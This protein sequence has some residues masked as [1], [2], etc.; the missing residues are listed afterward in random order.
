MQK[1]NFER[2]YLEIKIPNEIILKGVTIAT[3]FKCSTGR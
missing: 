1:Q 2:F 3:H